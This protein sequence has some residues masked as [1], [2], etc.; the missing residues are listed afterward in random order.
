MLLWLQRAAA[1]HWGMNSKRLLL[2][3]TLLTMTGCQVGVFAAPPWKSL[4]PPIDYEVEERGP[5]GALLKNPGPFFPGGRYVLLHE[6]R[7]SRLEVRE[8]LA[9][10]QLASAALY[11]R[12]GE[13][14]VRHPIQDGALLERQ[15]V[16][17]LPKLSSFAVSADGG[18]LLLVDPTGVYVV[19][20]GS[21]PRRVWEGK[22]YAVAVD[23]KRKVAWIAARGPLHVVDR[24]RLADGEVTL[25]L[26]LPIELDSPD[27][28]LVLSGPNAALYD[29][30][31][32]LDHA[33][34]IWPERGMATTL[35]R[36]WG[37][38]RPGTVDPESQP[39]LIVPPGGSEGERL[40]LG[41]VP[42]RQGE[43]RGTLAPFPGGRFLLVGTTPTR[44][45]DLH[46]EVL[47][48]E[49]DRVRQ[50]DLPW[51]STLHGGW[52][53]SVSWDA[54][55]VNLL[56]GEK[57]ARVT[58]SE[59]H[60]LRIP[61][62]E[63]Q[64]ERTGAEAAIHALRWVGGAFVNLCETAVYLPVNVAFSAMVAP[65]AAVGSLGDRQLL[66]WSVAP[67]WWPWTYTFGIELDW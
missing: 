48:L 44:G 1:Y 67:L 41:R 5:A 34:L 24:V 28:E 2:L 13:R 36:E 47:E 21:K 26:P 55:G 12:V 4:V 65:F 60:T 6:G 52:I 10:A 16:A 20:A 22:P 38:G 45:A 50:R 39:P 25:R 33:L 63:P 30:G 27:L 14:V 61:G 18:T 15:D 9:G 23:A 54:F 7:I 37:N 57:I 64:I 40:S 29:D 31:G 51:P 35:E 46:L 43:Q 66:P 32:I 53:D 58:P 49:D 8:S 59:C 11:R 56:Q 17:E 3:A 42:G 19:E 62:Y